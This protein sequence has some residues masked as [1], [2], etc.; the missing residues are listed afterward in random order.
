MKTLFT[1][2]ALALSLTLSAKTY[3]GA[4]IYSTQ[5]VLYGKFEMCMQASKA[6]GILSTFFLYKNGSEVSGAGWEEIDIEIFGKNNALSFQSNIITGDA[7]AKVNSEQV[8]TASSSLADAFHI[9]T[10]EWTPD[11]IAWYLDGVELRKT[12]GAQVAACS[13]AMSYRF[14]TWISDS[15]PWVG[16]FTE[17]DLPKH[18]FVDWLTYSTYTKGT[19]DDGSD[20]TFSWKDDFTTFNTS[21]WSKATWTFDGNLVDYNINNVK[22]QDG[23]LILSITTAVATGF[24][25]TVPAGSCSSNSSGSINYENLN[26]FVSNKT[27]FISNG[28][29]T[30][31]VTLTDISGKKVFS[32]MVSE[33]AL[34]N[35]L[36]SGIYIATVYSEQGSFNKKIVLE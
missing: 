19:G 27:L 24:T 26:V 11:Y 22:A 10:L 15:A 5:T 32:K 14:N 13:K 36:P 2:T 20:F 35:D 23:K 16:T 1:I 34:L 18:Q 8:H 28:S 12:T 3:K 30:N 25:G 33:F 7:S 9:Y 29:T 31:L 4:E 17:S 21:R 6:S